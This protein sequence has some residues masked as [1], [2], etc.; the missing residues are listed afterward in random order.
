MM[1]KVQ[2]KRRQARR[3]LVVDDE[4]SVREMLADFLELNNFICLQANDGE[5]AVDYTKREQF[6]LLID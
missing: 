3:V 4:P 2:L 6:D 1:R 5:T